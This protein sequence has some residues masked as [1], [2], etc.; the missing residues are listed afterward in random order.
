MH[1]KMDPANE[2]FPEMWYIKNKK[3]L[4]AK[5]MTNMKNDKNLFKIADVMHFGPFVYQITYISL[6]ACITSGPL[7]VS[8]RFSRNIESSSFFPFY[9]VVIH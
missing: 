8:M 7:F 4:Y 2:H 1:Y 9:F 6:S 3:K 5:R